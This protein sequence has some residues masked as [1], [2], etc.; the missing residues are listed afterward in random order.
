MHS[1]RIV[2]GISVDFSTTIY[3]SAEDNNYYPPVEAAS[4]L[5]ANE[6]NK[7]VMHILS[8]IE[9]EKLGAIY[10]KQLLQYLPIEGLSLVDFDS[11]WVYGKC[12]SEFIPFSLPV[13]KTAKSHDEQGNAYYYFSRNLT[14]SQQQ[15][16]N[17]FHAV[18]ACQMSHA[19]ELRHT[20]K[21]VTK[22]VL[23]GLGNRSGFNQSVTRE[24]SHARRQK[25][26]FSLLMIDLDNFKRVN[27][28]FGHSE[29]DKV[30][31]K[32]A[33][34]LS[35][36]LRDTDEAFRFGGDEFCCILDCADQQQLACAATRIQQH[37]NGSSYLRK[38]KVSCSIGG[39]VCQYEDD[40]TA[41]F[42][43]ADAALYKVKQNGKNGYRAA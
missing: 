31:I 21:M 38:M 32:V 16:I 11:R 4:S 30:L 27:D 41:L 33:N 40:M 29:G 20:R 3:D 15:I 1:N 26:T 19:L 25:S 7:F 10:H 18:F 12:D 36:S 8:T 23:T 14:L 34:L 37:I 35:Q 22:D 9:L 13:N 39:T 24:L 42:D 43:R 28:S 17:Q 2:R 6:F 5:S